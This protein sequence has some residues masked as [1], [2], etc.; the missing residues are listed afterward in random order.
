VPPHVVE[1]QEFLSEIPERRQ[2]LDGGVGDARL[3]LELG[4]IAHHLHRF[5][6]EAGD[7]FGTVVFGQPMV[8]A[9][10]DRPRRVARFGP[11]FGFLFVLLD[12]PGD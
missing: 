4:E 6:V 10:I 7:R 9:V 2:P 1:V 3:V 12:H 11:L 8:P 5:A